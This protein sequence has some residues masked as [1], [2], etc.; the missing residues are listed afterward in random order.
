[1]KRA[2]KRANLP[3][4]GRHSNNICVFREVGFFTSGLHPD[5][6]EQGQA[7]SCALRSQVV[8]IGNVSA[9]LLEG[10]SLIP[11]C[12]VIMLSHGPHTQGDPERLLVKVRKREHCCGVRTT[13]KQKLTLG[14]K[15]YTRMPYVR[16]HKQEAFS[17]QRAGW[18]QP[19]RVCAVQPDLR[20]P[21]DRIS[22]QR[23]TCCRLRI[24]S[25]DRAGHSTIKRWF[26]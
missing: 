9:C 4:R 12:C 18:I 1:M 25:H 24:S 13:R 19:N 16:H 21:D 2:F 10:Q 17:L 14:P 8:A 5:E 7:G 20:T 15:I 11:G 26:L 22:K 23:S 6:G 3:G